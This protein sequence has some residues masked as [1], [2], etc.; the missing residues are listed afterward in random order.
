V[1]VFP[2]IC[3]MCSSDTGRRVIPDSPEV[4]TF[5]CGRC[6]HV[7]SEPAPAYVAG[8]AEDEDASRFRFPFRR[9]P[10]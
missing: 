1:I 2:A 4:Q 5:R 10:K 9:K 7:W 6:H 3:P 8:P